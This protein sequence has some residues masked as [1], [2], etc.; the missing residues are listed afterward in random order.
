MAWAPAVFIHVAAGGVGI[1]TGFAALAVRKGDRLHRAA[2]AVFFAAMLAMTGFAAVLAALGA[3]RLNTIAAV[4]TL[5]LVATAWMAARRADGAIGRFEAV[6]MVAPLGVVAAGLVFARQALSAAGL[7]DGDPSSGDAATLYIA[8]AS[9]AAL[10]AA[11]DLS[12][13]ARQGLSGADRIS[14]HLWRMCLALFIAAGSF[15]FGQAD[16]IPAALRGPHLAIPPFAALGALAFWLV[17]VRLPVRKAAL[18]RAV[19]A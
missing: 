9:L 18:G 13:L 11:L 6:A 14:R 17:R 8:F 1:A 10:A 5:Y 7:A 3:Q 16:E 19:G 4:F 2:G 15:F 12:V